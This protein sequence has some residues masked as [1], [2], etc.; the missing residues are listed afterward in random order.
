MTMKM[1]KGTRL[2][3]R[4]EPG[5]LGVCWEA[6]AEEGWLATEEERKRRGRACM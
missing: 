3:C 2:G 6:D 4:R 5:T 1:T